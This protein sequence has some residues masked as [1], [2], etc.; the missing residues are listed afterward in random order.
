[1]DKLSELQQWIEIADSD[2]LAAQYLAKNMKVES[3]KWV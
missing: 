2:L 1:M 3:S